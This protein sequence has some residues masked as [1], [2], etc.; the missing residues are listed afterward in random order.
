MVMFWQVAGAFFAVWY[1]AVL[2]NS[3]RKFLLCSASIGA[4]GWFLY[5]LL[6]R[7]TG[8]LLA[9][10]FA[11]LF[12]AGAG[13]LV[14]RWLKT[15]VTLFLIPGFYPLVPGIGMFQTALAVI[16][17]DMAA[18]SSNFQR[19][20]LT[21]AMIALSIFTMDSLVNSS[22]RLFRFAHR[23]WLSKMSASDATAHDIDNVTNIE[24]D[25][26]ENI[27]IDSKN[28]YPE[29]KGPKL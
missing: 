14:A 29:P 20:L 19:T 15:P 1:T 11:G 2:V 23:R 8:A 24:I 12:I 4:L 28:A 27:N 26:D 17:G 18:F 7:H 10:Y 22:V 3:P 9:N 16:Q 13:H 5:L 6:E 25:I 21:A